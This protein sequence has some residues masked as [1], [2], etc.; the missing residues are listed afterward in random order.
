[1]C[2]HMRMQA[3]IFTAIEQI[4]SYIPCTTLA[5]LRAQMGSTFVTGTNLKER[6][7][8]AIAREG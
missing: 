4:D 2:W 1:M 8:T 5:S 6:I 7:C 3:Y